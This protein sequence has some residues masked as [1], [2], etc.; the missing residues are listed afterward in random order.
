MSK[1]GKYYIVDEATGRKFCV[2]PITD[3]PNR[4]LWGDVNPATH[5]LEGNY[6]KKHIGAIPESESSI[7]E[8][9]GFKNIITLKPGENPEDYINKLLNKNNEHGR[10]GLI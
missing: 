4:K 5:E 7:T 2:E 6:G 8:E 1:T 3:S 9:N 10:D